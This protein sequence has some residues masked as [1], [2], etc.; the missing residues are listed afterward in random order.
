MQSEVRY[1]M[2]IWALM[3]ARK[4]TIHVQPPRMQVPNWDRSLANAPEK[5]WVN[6]TATVISGHNRLVVVSS[7]VKINSM[8]S[9]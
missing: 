8:R 5:T 4:L 3:S 2:A 1:K 6:T 9:R 7:P